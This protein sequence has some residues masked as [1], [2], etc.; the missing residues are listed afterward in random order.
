[1]WLKQ[2]KTLEFN[3]D[4]GDN[5]KSCRELIFT[6][7]NVSLPPGKLYSYIVLGFFTR[8]VFLC[9]VSGR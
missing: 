7:H 1:M 8:K 2:N 3:K 9:S 4:P 5:T 6:L